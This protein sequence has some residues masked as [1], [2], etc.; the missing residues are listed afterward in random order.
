MPEP[1]I[2]YSRLKLTH[3]THTGK[4]LHKSHT[5]YPLLALLL[6]MVGVIL[7]ATTLQVMAADVT[8]TAVANGSPPVQAA[9]IL[10]PEQNDS[11]T[12]SSVPVSGTCE[13]G[14]YIKLYRNDIFSGAAICTVGGTFSITTDLFTGRNDLQARTYNIAD[15]EGP[16]SQIVTVYYYTPDVGEPIDP[17]T[18][19]PSYQPGGKP[20]P[21]TPFYLAT[22]YF[23]KAAFS[24]QKISWDFEIMGGKGPY[25]VYVVWGDG[26]SDVYTDKTGNKFTIEHV[27][28]TL[29]E[30]REHYALTVRV[31]DSQGYNASLQ[32]ISIMNDPN[33]ISGALVRPNDSSP[34]GTINLFSGILKL[35][36]SAYGVILLMG[37]A[38]WLGERR[39]ESIAAA[40][41]RRRL[42]RRQPV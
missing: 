13:A 1:V 15:N 34:F 27:Y 14:Y 22:E 32:L 24:G 37:I 7:T 6:L 30:Q 9:V 31:V 41:Y 26:Y 33:I 28:N 39:G 38:F 25:T 35:V 16:R 12:D 21:D 29:K 36:W 2:K 10:S 19:P 42:R 23:F 17:D 40:W 5:S 18:K 3:R 20:D 8:V 11:F 4:K